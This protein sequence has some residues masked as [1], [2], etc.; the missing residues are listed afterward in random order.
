V[1]KIPQDLRDNA[2]KLG[3]DAD[4][5]ERRTKGATELRKLVKRSR[6]DEAYQASKMT[7]VDK[8]TPW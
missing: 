3:I 1:S 6:D 7:F 8:S 5:F 2:T 4:R